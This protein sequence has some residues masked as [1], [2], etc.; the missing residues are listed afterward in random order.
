MNTLTQEYVSAPVHHVLPDILPIVC[1]DIVYDVLD[2]YDATH[3]IRCFATTFPAHEP[4]TKH[5]RISQEVFHQFAEMV[6]HKAVIAGL[7]ISAKDLYTGNLLGCLISED[8]E[9]NPPADLEYIHPDFD[10]I[11]ALLD[12]LDR[13]YRSQHLSFPNEILHEFMMSVYPDHKG[14]SIGYNLVAASHALGRKKGFKSAIAEVTGPISQ[15]VFIDKHEYQV[16][17]EIAYN[18]F[19]FDCRLCFAG[20]TDSTHCKLVHKDLYTCPQK[21]FKFFATRKA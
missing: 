18:N 17:E 19:E 4:M 21:G 16:L 3:A 12:T 5:L 1:D 10:P 2:D 20:I 8:F 11:F 13:S 14:R 6:V 15:S 7:S 9:G